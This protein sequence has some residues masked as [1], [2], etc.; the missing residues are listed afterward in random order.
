MVDET[1]LEGTS[2]DGCRKCNFE[3]RGLTA[4][5][6]QFKSLWETTMANPPRKNP[7]ESS[8]ALGRPTAQEIGKEQISAALRSER[9]AVGGEMVLRRV[10]NPVVAIKLPEQRVIL[11][12]PAFASLF[13]TTPQSLEG[14]NL[15]LGETLFEFEI[16]W[17]A[18]RK[19]LSRPGASVQRNV[20]VSATAQTPFWAHATFTRLDESGV[21]DTVILV[22]SDIS[23]LLEVRATLARERE[24]FER[25][26]RDVKT[27]EDTRTR[28]LGNI[29]GKLRN[30]VV[31]VEGHA[32]QL[33]LA[34]AD[35]Q[36]DTV[37][38]EL[39]ECTRQMTDLVQRIAHLCAL[40]SNVEIRET[41][42]D[43]W[44]FLDE[45][46]AKIA[47]RGDE[48]GIEVGLKLDGRTRRRVLVDSKI[49]DQAI[50]QLANTL[51]A[52]SGT[53]SL[54]IEVDQ[55]VRRSIEPL[56]RVHMAC[57]GKRITQSRFDAMRKLFGGEPVDEKGDT[58]DVGIAIMHARQLTMA[59]G[60]EVV[61]SLPSPS[62]AE[63]ALQ[64]PL[65][66]VSSEIVDAEDRIIPPV[67]YLQ[68]KSGPRWEG[69]LAA[70]TACR[71][72]VRVVDRLREIVEELAI[73]SKA[74][75]PFGPYAFVAPSRSLVRDLEMLDRALEQRG[76]QKMRPKIICLPELSVAS[77]NTD[78]PPDS[79]IWSLPLRYAD[80]RES[81]LKLER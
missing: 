30:A 73:Q 17:H 23:S 35:R 54:L 20:L 65:K 64:I 63:V 76:L 81:L 71:F 47:K 50:S 48:V 79:L 3:E 8:P 57:S 67:V 1:V 15:S 43:L 13:G 49:L 9:A 51:F 70:A 77:E 41:E 53:G 12:N 69:V 25:T 29:A 21:T 58:F 37:I 32:A 34:N 40:A 74:P 60:G 68:R 52:F 7:D 28:L 55:R 44:H 2:L 38:K 33:S 45:S 61:A 59:L 36:A 75:N 10:P 46:V 27:V 80:L 18:V 42:V 19:Q 62:Q 24:G 31:S 5:S 22:L 16:E 39:E 14:T 11:A 72:D 78:L 6:L 4:C 56:L 66:V 26:M